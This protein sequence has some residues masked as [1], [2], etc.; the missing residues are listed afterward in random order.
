[1]SRERW[2]HGVAEC[3]RCDDQPERR[4]AMQ[5]DMA[6][7]LIAEAV[8]AALEEGLRHAPDPVLYLRRAAN[9]VLM[10]LTAF[11]TASPREGAELRAIVAEEVVTVSREML[12]RQRN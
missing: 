4:D 10:V 3:A 12:R 8:R 1:M 5:D 11:D 6:R 7:Q 2:P 9:E